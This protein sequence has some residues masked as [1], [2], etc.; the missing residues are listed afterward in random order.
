MSVRVEVW[1]D[2]NGC[3]ESFGPC[4]GETSGRNAAIAAH[5]MP[6]RTVGSY[7]PAERWRC[8]DCLGRKPAA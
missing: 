3:G 7:A 5:W 8:P 2:C 1:I 4:A 6:F